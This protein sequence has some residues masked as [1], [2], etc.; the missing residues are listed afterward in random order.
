MKRKSFLTF[1]FHTRAYVKQSY[2]LIARLYDRML[3]L[4][5][6]ISNHIMHRLDEHEEILKEIRDVVVGE[7]DDPSDG[8]E[9]E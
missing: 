3:G 6:L 2:D 5:R 7:S 9:A 8:Q 4:E 1:L